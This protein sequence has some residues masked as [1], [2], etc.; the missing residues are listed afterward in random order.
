[1][2][3]IRKL[4][5]TMGILFASSSLLVSCS[6]DDYPNM[7]AIVV[8]SLQTTSS[9]ATAYWTVVSNGSCDGYKVVINEGTR[10]NKGAEVVNQTFQ[11][12]EYNATFNGLKANTTYVITTQAIPSKSSGRTNAD[13]YEMQFVTAPLVSGISFGSV[14]YNEDNKGT[15][16]V[17]WSAID[18]SNC[19]GYTVNID[20][21]QLG[22]DNQYSWANLK[23]ETLTGAS[24][25]SVK[26]EELIEPEKTYRVRVRPNP[27]NG[28][29]YA[30]GEFTASDD[31]KAPAVQ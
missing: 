2:S 31:F 19:G 23:S 9:S 12:K 11:P 21:G 14:T 7:G 26:F 13:T 20:E 16:T 27:R 17:S 1:M 6:D 15:V 8:N 28:C 29:W 4:V 30:A 24:N 25:T 3:R 10:A 5:A 18:E 22:D